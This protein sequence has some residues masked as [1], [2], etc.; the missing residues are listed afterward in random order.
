MSRAKPM[1]AAFGPPAAEL[2]EPNVEKRPIANASAAMPT[3]TRTYTHHFG[4]EGTAA[5]DSP[6]GADASSGTSGCGAL[7]AAAGSR[8][9]MRSGRVAV[10]VDAAR[11]DGGRLGDVLASP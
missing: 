1:S 10:L 7:A 9:L 8:S 3:A 2:F 11:A 4:R 6:F 5:T